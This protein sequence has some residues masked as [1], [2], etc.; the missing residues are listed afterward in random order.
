MSLRLV[1]V[2]T[3]VPASLSSIG[4]R[5]VGSMLNYA[6]FELREVDKLLIHL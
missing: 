6:V 3:L 1:I 5:V 4:V 2:P